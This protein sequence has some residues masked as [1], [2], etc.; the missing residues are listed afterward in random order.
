MIDLPGGTLTFLFTDIEGSTA[1]LA[2]LGDAYE[3][4]LEEH[5]R[6]IRGAVGAAGGHEVNTEG[7]AIFAVFAPRRLPSLL[8]QLLRDGPPPEPLDVGV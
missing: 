7:D 1:L 4:I 3:P 8:R 2:R 5:R 6:R